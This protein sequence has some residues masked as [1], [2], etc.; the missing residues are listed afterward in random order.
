LR[1]GR[2]GRFEVVSDT[3]ETGDEAATVEEVSDTARVGRLGR[4]EVV[5]DT[6]ET[7]DEAATVEEVSDTACVSGD[8]GGSNWCQTPLRPLARRPLPKGV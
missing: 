2:L 6:T 3:T 5:S 4:F 1:V 8:W 7:G